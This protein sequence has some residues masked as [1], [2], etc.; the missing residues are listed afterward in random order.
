M[1]S[2]ETFLRFVFFFMAFTVFFLWEYIN[3]RRA[4]QHSKWFRWRFHFLLIGVSILLM[5]CLIFVSPVMVAHHVETHGWGLFQYLGVLKPISIVAS[6]VLMD[7]VIYWQ[8]VA[9]HKIP[10]LWRW[11]ALHHADQ[12]F[13]VST[14]IRFHP[15]EM[16]LSLLFKSLVIF[17]LG[18]P[19]TAVL[20]FEI[21]LNLMSL[22]TH[23]NIYLN[24][25]VDNVLRY[26]LVTP[27]MHQIHHSVR[28]DES[29]SNFGF[30]L[31][32]WDRIFKTYKNQPMQGY[33]KMQLGLNE[34]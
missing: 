24:T 20:I 10:W 12:D 34:E 13:D 1:I 28:W 9:F 11:H 17:I 31:V 29:N 19:V 5:R 14:G 18:V 2:T 8:H 4:L 21:L 33:S 16:I 7:L 3:P 27:Y 30:N 22:F 25:H 23:A 15:I 32:W 6:L 26:F